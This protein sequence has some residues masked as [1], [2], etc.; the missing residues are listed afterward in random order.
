M[1][2]GALAQRDAA[3]VCLGAKDQLPGQGPQFKAGEGPSGCASL[4]VDSKGT[5]LPQSH[6]LHMPRGLVGACYDPTGQFCSGVSGGAGAAALEKLPP[7]P[8]LLPYAPLP[9]AFGC[10]IGS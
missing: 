8:Q 10:C 4:Q 3:Q 1:P 2:G 5:L 7:S 6:L 9:V